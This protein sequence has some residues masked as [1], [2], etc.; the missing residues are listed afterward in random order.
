MSKIKA[1]K[2]GDVFEAPAPD[3]EGEADF[4]VVDDSTPV[5]IDVPPATPGN[6]TALTAADASAPVGA[7]DSSVGEPVPAVD[8]STGATSGD[9]V[10][11]TD[12]A[13][14]STSGD[15]VGNVVASDSSPTSLGSG[16]LST[17]PLTTTDVSSPQDQTAASSSLNDTE[18]ADNATP[19]VNPGT[20]PTD[21]VT[22]SPTGG[23]TPGNG[24]TLDAKSKHL[25]ATQLEA[26]VLF[27]IAQL[28]TVT[29]TI[30][31][32]ADA[33]FAQVTS[34]IDVEATL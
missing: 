13:S 23:P 4:Q 5:T 20:P 28:I 29:D 16:A 14:G 8:A 2:T 21:S 18:A 15:V 19:V 30:S 3:F 27:A 7:T 34:Q 32:A 25:V 10:S 9:A 26:D 1:L 31:H 11:G 17:S 6:G 33:F 12:T 24:A 22:S